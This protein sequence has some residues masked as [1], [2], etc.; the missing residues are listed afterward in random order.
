MN[1]KKS[2]FLNNMETLAISS[3]RAME[4]AQDVLKKGG[5]VIVPTDTV[6][7]IIG[8]ARN[9]QVITKIFRAKKRSKTQALG[10][11]VADQA[12]LEEYVEIPAVYKESLF[13]CWPGPLTGVFHSKGVL[14]KILE[15]GTGNIGIRIP[16]SP[17]IIELIQEFH[18]PLVQT[19]ANISGRGS[20]TKS[21]DV[22]E[23]FEGSSLIELFIDG[24]DLPD[25]IPSTG[26]DF[27]RVPPRIFREG[28]LS[29]EKLEDIF[30]LKFQ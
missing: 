29:K 5:L 1:Q 7:G 23:D 15:G 14:P 20:Y 19:S 21:Q 8:D 11:F 2:K 24:G 12:T 9:P 30:D 26:V 16:R 10:I 18:A 27:T 6:Y 17:F 28:P 13:K 22:R 3:S 25:T 4:S